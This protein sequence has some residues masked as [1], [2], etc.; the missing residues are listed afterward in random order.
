MYQR[1]LTLRD[2]VA[3]PLI[4]LLLAIL[5]WAILTDIAAAQISVPLVRVSA[6]SGTLIAKDR[7]ITACHVVTDRWGNMRHQQ[8]WFDF[9]PGVQRVG[10]EF[11]AYSPESR[12]DVVIFRIA[13][14][15]ATPIAIASEIPR[16]GETVYVAGYA[17]DGRL[18]STGRMLG[19]KGGSQPR[20]LLSVSINR[21]DSGG[22]VL[23]S[24]REF[25]GVLCAK[26]TRGNQPGRTAAASP[27]VTSGPFACWL[28]GSGGCP[29]CPPG[30]CPQERG[31]GF[32][33]WRQG[34]DS[35]VPG[36]Y[37]DSPL[38]PDPPPGYGQLVPIPPRQQTPPP[39]PPRQQTPPPSIS[40]DCQQQ[41]DCL[42]KRVDA[43]SL[44]GGC[45]DCEAQVVVLK[46][47][48]VTLT[49]EITSLR[50]S[51]KSLNTQFAALLHQFRKQIEPPTLRS[52][53]WSAALHPGETIDLPPMRYQAKTP[54]GKVH[55]PVLEKRLGG[56]ILY[57]KSALLK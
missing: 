39:P 42:R 20:M 2:H 41:L 8:C 31:G 48:V 45:S 49:K 44:R 6:A 50:V 1:K 15:N 57:V 47:E 35:I 34:R 12:R 28:G 27:V 43:L 14:V 30:Q 4:T 56:E 9:L 52:G 38:T 10:L 18:S 19:M 25:C 46:I 54:D 40:P 33:G 11:E 21:G 23:N 32:G 16:V 26:D 53:D 13:P 51:H 55:G 5:P 24:N 3:A 7:V 22:C 37:Q 17:P 36:Q 29:N